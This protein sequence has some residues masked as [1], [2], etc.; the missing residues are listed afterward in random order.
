VLANDTTAPDTGETLQITAVGDPPHGTASIDANGT[1][2]NTA[3]DVVRY[4]PDAGYSG[5]DSFTYTIADGNGGTDT[6]TVNVTVNATQ[7]NL[8]GNPGFET[9]LTG[10]GPSGT[11]VVLERVSG[12]H[13]GSW[14][15]RIRNSGTSSVTMKLDDSPNWVSVS[16]TGTYTVSLWAR[17]DSAGA[18]LTLKIREYA[19]STNIASRSS[20]LILSTS[21]QK[22]SL[23]YT[24]AR[25]GTSTLDL[26]AYITGGA[27]ASFL[28]DD[29][30]I[31]RS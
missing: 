29:V 17:A 14:S 2:G 26:T 28:V 12:G 4:T 3:D 31:V 19:S 20:D 11:K 25:P 5:P 16:T 30:S 10:W 24:A 13:S 18:K 6:A 8:V 1:S 23:T 15:A 27:G 21:W 7:T 9:N 22:V